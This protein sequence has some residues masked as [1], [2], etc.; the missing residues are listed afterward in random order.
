MP[1]GATPVRTGAQRPRLQSLPAAQVGSAGPDV[2]EFARSLGYV[3]DDW[4]EWCLYGIFAEDADDRLCASM[5]LVLMPRQ[6]GKNVL[7]EIAELYAFFVLDWPIILHTAHRQDTSADHMSRLVT[8]IRE[9]PSLDEITEVFFANGK[10]RIARTD[11]GASIRFVTRSKKI[12]RGRSPRMIVFDEALYLQDEHLQALLPSMS[13]QT[14]GDDAPM[15]IY[16]SSAPVLESAVLHRV[17]AAC[18]A[19]TITE[20]FYAEWGCAEGV[21]P[22]DRNAWYMSNPGLG[23]RISEQWVAETELA[24]M[25]PE[26]FLIERLGVVIPPSAEGAPPVIDATA[27]QATA[28]NSSGEPGDGELIV[29]VDVSPGSEWA[30]VAIGFGDR[31][32]PYVEVIRH[33]KGVGWVPEYLV[34]LVQRRNPRMVAL[35]GGGPAGALV[36][37]L[38]AAF[39]EAG[40][41]SDLIEQMTTAAM[42][43]A[44]SGFLADVVEG[45]LR[46]PAEGQGALDDAVGVA[47]DRRV[48]DA[49]LFERRYSSTPISPLIAAVVA[50]S[51]LVPGDA[52]FAGGVFVLADFLEDGD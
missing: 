23:V 36:G 45:R 3:L 1:E 24:I 32:S 43:Q 30:S 15:M 47:T 28:V 27:W 16:T 8:V 42:K 14:L 2:V 50:R 38:L 4:Q 9:N 29:A 40:I 52:V 44:C 33:E 51:L 34:G 39:R 7:L 5:A 48:G 25:S 41:S 37:P 21:D 10:E 20:A 17:R 49:W 19:G 46:H 26:A 22:E 18:E 6:N 35:D 11:T 31:K 12:G 13:A